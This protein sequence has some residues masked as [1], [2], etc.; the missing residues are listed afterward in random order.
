MLSS[1]DNTGDDDTHHL[2]QPRGKGYVFHA[3]TPKSL[4][5]AISPWTGKPFGNEIKLGLG[6][7]DRT[8]AKKR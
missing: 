1:V 7:R 8:E 4:I 3:R 2:Q 5:D 6:T